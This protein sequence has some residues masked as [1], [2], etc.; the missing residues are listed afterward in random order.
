MT[1]KKLYCIVG[2]GKTGLSCV[3][4]GLKQ[5]WQMVVTDSRPTPPGLEELNSINQQ[6]T[7]AGKPII[8][9][10]FGEIST[11]L[12][13]QADQ[14]ILS[15]GV[16]LRLPAIANAIQ[17]GKPCVGDI[18]IFLQNIT[19]PVI[20]VTGSNAKS[21]VTTL[22]GK[23]A[24]KSGLTAITAGNIGTPVLDFLPPTKPVDVYVLELSSFQL[25]TTNSL[26]AAAAT[27]LNICEDH[28]DRHADMEEYI[29][30]KQIAYR[31]SKVNVVN[32]NDANTWPFK[33]G[34][35]LTSR[36]QEQLRKKFVIH[37]DNLITTTKQ[38]IP[39]HPI[40]FSLTKN[41]I[42]H[43]YHVIEEANHTYLAVDGEI[44]LDIDEMKIFGKHNVENALA[45]LALGDA[46]KLSR[47]AMIAVLKEF[48]GLPHRCQLIREYH[49][50]KWYD[51]S[52]GTNV[53]A[54][55][56]AIE[57][58]A[59]GMKGKII[60]IAGGLGKGADFSPLKTVVPRLV[61]HVILMGEAA[62]ELYELFHHD[63]PTTT[64]YS[65]EE[66]IKVA[67]NLIQPNDIVLLS[68]ACASFD[69]F[70]DY[71]HRGNEFA[72]FVNALL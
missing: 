48:T 71:V 25:A 56:A 49:N 68:P 10:S 15:P 58:L 29:A 28:L 2:L 12:I 55:L 43:C 6:L 14:L 35:K 52:K 61:K 65:M 11:S 33:N 21:T 64:V 54:S 13:E 57:G 45:A 60:L 41:K 1:I 39:D 22:V 72:K 50:V 5:N 34:K 69:M 59:K 26:S 9:S 23:M 20:A 38:P 37:L 44:L 63:C 7:A 17:Q 40:F 8:A 32:Y 36:E 18:E 3:K 47:A 66:A 51:D 24:E 27:V 62:K 19:S 70:K 46:I 30:A 42:S 31:N 67:A 4:F 16:D 53:G